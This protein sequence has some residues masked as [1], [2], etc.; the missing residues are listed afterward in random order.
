MRCTVDDQQ[1]E[2]YPI[3][4]TTQRLKASN[5]LAWNFCLTS[6]NTEDANMLGWLYKRLCNVNDVRL[7]SVV[8]WHISD[9]ITDRNNACRLRMLTSNHLFLLIRSLPRDK[10]L[11]RKNCS[12]HPTDC[13]EQV[14]LR[15]MDHVYLGCHRTQPLRRSILVACTCIFF[16]L[17]LG[18]AFFNPQYL[19]H[20]ASCREMASKDYIYIYIYLLT[21]AMYS[22]LYEVCKLYRSLGIDQILVMKSTILIR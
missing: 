18:H 16:L 21:Q 10:T 3:P 9:H 13:S 17:K 7:I 19:F 15:D 8:P 5:H 14:Y 6:A 20:T 11:S 1:S 2:L 12:P 4:T 22:I